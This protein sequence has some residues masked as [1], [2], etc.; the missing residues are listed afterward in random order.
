MCPLNRSMCNRALS[1]RQ[2]Q[3]RK[4]TPAVCGAPRGV[5]PLLIHKMKKMWRHARR[6]VIIIFS[7]IPDLIFLAVHLDCFSASQQLWLPA[8]GTRLYPTSRSLSLSASTISQLHLLSL[9]LSLH[10]SLTHTNIVSLCT[11]S[12][13]K[14]NYSN[15][16]KTEDELTGTQEKP[17]TEVMLV[18]LRGKV[19]DR[20]RCSFSPFNISEQKR[21]I[22][23]CQKLLFQGNVASRRRT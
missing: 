9:S 19:V 23:R 2:E 14:K 5:Y 10:V 20:S 6:C 12:M 16:M 18:E 21:H 11:L 3:N 15:Y 22:L 8:F 13:E 4:N 17:L 7:C 1:S